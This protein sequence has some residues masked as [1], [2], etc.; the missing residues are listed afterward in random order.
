[1]LKKGFPRIHVGCFKRISGD[2]Y[3]EGV[4]KE[5]PGSYIQGVLK[6]IPGNIQGVSKEI[7]GNIHGVSKGNIGDTYRV[8]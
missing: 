4:V 3:R 1:M 2:A 6:R 8:F 7:P 5:I